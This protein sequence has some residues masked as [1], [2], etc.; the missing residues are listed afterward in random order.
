[1]EEHEDEVLI[2]DTRI[3]YRR[4]IIQASSIFISTFKNILN[5][6]NEIFFKSDNN[7]CQIWPYLFSVTLVYVVTL[8]LFPAVCVL[9][10]SS[11]N[12]HGF[13]WNGSFISN[14][15]FVLLN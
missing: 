11:S 2:V 3:C 1:M 9:I 14:Y 12:G 13:L 7:F 15:D 10:R 5:L 8:S 6:I 4:I